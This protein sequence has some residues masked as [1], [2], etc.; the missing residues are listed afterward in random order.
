[1]KKQWDLIIKIFI[2]AE[3]RIEIESSIAEM[4]KWKCV[5]ETYFVSLRRTE[6]LEKKFSLKV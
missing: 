1:M 3:M 4:E 5:L 6:V 2:S